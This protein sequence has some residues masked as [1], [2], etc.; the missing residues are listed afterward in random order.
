MA[1]A[2]QSVE[3]NRG[4]HGRG[5]PHEPQRDLAKR[6]DLEI[7]SSLKVTESMP[8]LA[9]LGC[10]TTAQGNMIIH[11]GVT[12]SD[13]MIH[14]QQSGYQTPHLVLCKHQQPSNTQRKYTMI[15]PTSQTGKLS[16]RN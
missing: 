10:T 2:P 12:W 9:P 11:K 7:T 4:E 5:E 13:A 15:I 16:R 3:R 6:N 14:I 1:W 8:G